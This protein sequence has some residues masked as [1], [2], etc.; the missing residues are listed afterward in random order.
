[1]LSKRLKV[2]YIKDKKELI[3]VNSCTKKNE[4]K[5]SSKVN[6]RKKKKQLKIVS[7]AKHA[8]LGIQKDISIKIRWLK[9]RDR[10][11][12]KS[13]QKWTLRNVTLKTHK[14]SSCQ[15]AS[16]DLPNLL[17]PPVSIVYCSWE[18]FKAIS[19]AVI[20]RLLLVV[21]PSLVNVK[22]SRGVSR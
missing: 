18:V 12:W 3:V 21:L 22:G 5:D 20:Y 15:A 13:G 8:A 6:Q 17:S 10:I 4:K 2:D 19:R 14:S 16:T 11:C 1:M 9:V 7:T